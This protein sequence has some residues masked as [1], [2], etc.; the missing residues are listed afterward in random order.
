MEDEMDNDM[1]TGFA[2]MVL[3]SYRLKMKTHSGV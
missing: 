2:G 1:Q 3:F